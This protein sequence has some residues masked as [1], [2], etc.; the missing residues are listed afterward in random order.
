MKRLPLSDLSRTASFQF[1]DKHLWVVQPTFDNSFTR[2][3][4]TIVTISQLKLT[5]IQLPDQIIMEHILLYSF[6]FV[7]KEEWV[8]STDIVFNHFYSSA[9][10]GNF[11]A[12]LK[13]R[14]FLQIQHPST[15]NS[16]C[17]EGWAKNAKLFNIIHICFIRVHVSFVRP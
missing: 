12:V 1:L 14:F 8:E 17:K 13:G 2:C 9:L 16:E 15:S 7:C 10:S 6:L 5:S 3:L 4:S 11:L